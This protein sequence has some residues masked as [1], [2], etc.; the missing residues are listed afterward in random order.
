MTRHRQGAPRSGPSAASCSEATTAAWATS[1]QHLAAGRTPDSVTGSFGLIKH[2][3]RRP[4]WLFGQALSVLGLAFHAT[5]LHLGS[6][7][8]VLEPTATTLDGLLRQEAGRRLVSLDPNLRPGLVDDP[9]ALTAGQVRIAV[10]AAG[11]TVNYRAVARRSYD[12]QHLPA[13]LFRPGT[14]AR[15]ALVTCGG[16]FHH[17][18]YSHN[19]IVYAEPAA[20]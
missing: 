19:V 16:T 9:D 6:I 7:A 17:G 12:K 2:L 15:L 11:R 8:L 10:R 5:A 3:A 18:A 20:P 13:D 4:L 1:L 14:A